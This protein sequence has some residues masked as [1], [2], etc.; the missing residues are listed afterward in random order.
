MVTEILTFDFLQSA[1]YRKNNYYIVICLSNRKRKDFVAK[2][3]SIQEL[4]YGTFC[5]HN[6]FVELND[7]DLNNQINVIGLTN[8]CYDN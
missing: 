7:V 2:W 6:L 5:V 8:V 3:L 4:G 1:I